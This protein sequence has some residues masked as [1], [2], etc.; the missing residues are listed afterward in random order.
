MKKKKRKK[1][2]LKTESMLFF[3][4]FEPTCKKEKNTDRSTLEMQ[5]MNRKSVSFS[6]VWKH[7]DE[8]YMCICIYF[9]MRK[10][11]MIK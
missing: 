10:R 9:H 7:P 11:K 1:K 5:L 3:Y 6:P 4:F 2:K 8:L